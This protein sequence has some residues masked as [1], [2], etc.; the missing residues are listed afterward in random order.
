MVRTRAL[1]L[2]TGVPLLLIADVDVPLRADRVMVAWRDKREANR[3]ITDALP[4]LQRAKAVRVVSICAPEEADAEGLAAVAQRLSRHG[5]AVETAA[6][7]PSRTSVTL[8]LE[9]AAE[10]FA[11]DLIVA[12]VYSHSRLREWVLGGVTGELMAASTRHLLL[13]H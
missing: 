7:P 9:A 4:F 2:A 8:D 10:S 13:S 6:I 3:A 5:V 11:A 12:G 1:L